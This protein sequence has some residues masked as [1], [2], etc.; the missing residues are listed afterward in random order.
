MALHAE[1]VP[2]GL[3]DLS[4]LCVCSNEAAEKGRASVGWWGG[5]DG[6]ML[7][8]SGEGAKRLLPGQG[9]PKKCFYS[10]AA[11]GSK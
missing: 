11:L 7:P 1:S 10:L 3:A 6:L 9:N 5:N 4:H 2:Q 8:A